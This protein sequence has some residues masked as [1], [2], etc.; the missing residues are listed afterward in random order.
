MNTPMSP[1][2]D[3]ISPI[4]Q[5]RA[6]FPPNLPVSPN[7]VTSSQNHGDLY[8]QGQ[9]SD[10]LGTE[11]GAKEVMDEQ[12]LDLNAKRNSD[13]EP[14]AT[15]KIANFARNSNE[16]ASLDNRDKQLLNI[17]SEPHLVQ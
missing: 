3:V 10:N 2:T 11:L 17:D 16:F 8:V 1:E 4:A 13:I 14:D 6:I 12:D 15:I 9:L 5:Q 7:D